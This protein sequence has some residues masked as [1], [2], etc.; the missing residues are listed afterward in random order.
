MGHQ[1]FCGIKKTGTKSCI[2]NMKMHLRSF[3]VKPTEEVIIC[4]QKTNK[5]ILHVKPIIQLKFNFC[6][7]QIK[8]ILKKLLSP[9]NKTFQT[10]LKKCLHARRQVSLIHMTHLNSKI[11]NQHRVYK[12]H[13]PVL[14]LPIKVQL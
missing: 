9:I 6:W 2:P 8:K 12:K 13:L 4:Y 7:C 14:T 10:Q 3:Y 11:S 1:H 5:K